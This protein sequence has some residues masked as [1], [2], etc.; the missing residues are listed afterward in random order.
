MTRIFDDALKDTIPSSDNL[1]SFFFFS[2]ILTEL[3][4]LNDMPRAATVQAKGRLKCAT[5]GKRAFV[6]LLGPVVEI[7][8]RNSVNYQTIEQQIQQHQQQLVPSSSASASPA[9]SSA[10]A[11]ALASSPSPASA[12]L[13]FSQQQ[14]QPQL[15]LI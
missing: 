13:P 1:F 6:R 9:L 11:P 8:K 12:T 2:F 10:Q 4:L 3:A 14:Q 7:I 15:S 5:L